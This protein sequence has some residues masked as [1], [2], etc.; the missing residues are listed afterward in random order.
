[1][2]G[3]LTLGAILIGELIVLSVM[4][5]LGDLRRHIPL[6]LLLFALAS[7]LFALAVWRATRTQLSLQIILVAAIVLRVPMFF[8]DPSLSDD[9]WRYMHDGRAQLA[10]FSP[11]AYAPHDPRTM[12]YRAPE[13]ARINHPDVPTI[14]PPLAQMAFR[15]AAAFPAPL[16]TWRMFILAA[17]LML[18]LAAAAVLG[19]HRY[20]NLALYAW[21]P[22]A[23]TEAIGSAHLEPLAI[24]FLMLAIVATI[25]GG[26]LTCGIALAVSVAI[27][28]IAAPLIL[29]IRGKRAIMTF[30]VVLFVFMPVAL[31]DHNAV[32]TLTLFAQSWESNGSMFAIARPV[33]DGRVYRI[34]AAI[35][36]MT[37]LWILR[38]RHLPLPDAAAAF[39]LAFFILAPVVHPWYLLWI[40]ALLPLRTHP[41]DA[42]GIAA[43]L[44]TVT[45]VGSYVAHQQLLQTGV[46]RVPPFILF[47]EYVGVF[48]LL[49]YAW[50]RTRVPV[51]IPVVHYQ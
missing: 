10:G 24:T 4:A 29:L 15:L 11:Y 6:Y 3:K 32:G 51:R 1:M 9:V 42:V 41:F 20:G 27:K 45:V 44:W 43:L 25:R 38:R 31:T 39:F 23:I 2:R 46:W 12:P 50:V 13:F 28:L 26:A 19:K 48:G 47:I 35:L 7:L 8:T 22:L 18:L 14:Y 30:V 37:G 36:L 16:R 5:G 49:A 40:L 34:G 21:H 17:E 33:L